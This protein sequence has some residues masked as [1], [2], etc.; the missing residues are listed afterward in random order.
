MLKTNCMCIFQL[1]HCNIQCGMQ[2]S[3]KLFFV[4]PIA[5]LESKKIKHDINKF[6]IHKSDYD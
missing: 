4:A 6:R 5:S 1:N 2:N 3:S